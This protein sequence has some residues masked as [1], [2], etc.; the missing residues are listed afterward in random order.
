MRSAMHIILPLEQQLL[1]MYIVL[2]FLIDT[3]NVFSQE[4]ITHLQMKSYL[5][6]SQMTAYNIK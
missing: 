6:I 2:N 4:N 5:R 3:Y 1:Y